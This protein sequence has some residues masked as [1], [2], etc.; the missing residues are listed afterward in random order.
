MLGRRCRRWASIK[1]TLVRGLMLL[2][3][4][5]YAPDAGLILHQRLER[6]PNVRPALDQCQIFGDTIVINWAFCEHEQLVQC[7]FN[8][9]PASQTVAQH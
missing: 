4:R 3:E 8:V 9:G 2:S 5:K 1:G 6:W 7:W